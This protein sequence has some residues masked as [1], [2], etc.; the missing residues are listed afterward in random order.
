MIRPLRPLEM[1]SPTSFLGRVCSCRWRLPFVGQQL[2]RNAG[3]WQVSSQGR[4]RNS[5]GEVSHG[6][7]HGTGY[8]RV[9]IAT[10]FYYVH[11]LVATTFLGTPADESCW[12]VNHRDGDGLNNAVSNLQYMSPAENIKHS[13]ETNSSRKTCA[14]KL[15]KA[16]QWRRLGEQSW[17]RCSSQAEAARLLGLH[18]ASVSQCCRGLM[19]KARGCG[20]DEYYEFRDAP[21]ED[22]LL[23]DEEWRPA[24]CIGGLDSAIANMMVSSHGRIS[25]LLRGREVTNYGARHP[26]GY[27]SVSKSGRFMLV[28]RLVAATFLGQPR[29]PHLQVN[30]KDLDKGNNHVTNLEYV[31]GSENVRHAAAVSL[32]MGIGRNGT[33][34]KRVQARPKTGGVLWSEFDSI[35]TAAAQTGF[36]PQQVSRLCRQPSEGSS[37]D[38][39]FILQQSL[40]GEEWRAVVL[41]GARAPL[42]T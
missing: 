7:L 23:L 30:H 20:D 24:R 33:T 15:G 32:S 14:T 12:Q 41:P 42:A 22:K 39:Q 25:H 26:S 19:R 5:Y 31:T 9:Q 11:R 34:C 21:T 4:L 36:S 3:S 18:R 28:H 13:W 8:R 29:Y 6:S 37:W 27:Y 2:R 40:P 10:Q 35:K 38:F 17:S 1:T 16:V